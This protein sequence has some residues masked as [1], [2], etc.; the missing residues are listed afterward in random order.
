V[1]PNQPNLTATQRSTNPI[2]HNWAY[3]RIALPI[4]ALL[5][6]GAS[7]EKLAWS[8]AIGL[9]IGINPLLGS[10][11]VLCLV[12][13]SL[14]RLN[15]AASQLANHIVYPLELILI[16]PFI[17]IASR[18]FH[19]APMPLSANEL[20]RAARQRPLDL[21]R[22]LWHWE[23]HAFLLWAAIA[24]VAIPLIALALTPLLRKLLV[25]VEHHQ[26][27]ILHPS[28]PSA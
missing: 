8:I 26:Y 21:T 14:F 16:I 15:L 3:R 6:M 18:I 24:T 22:Q 19:S 1:K 28:D 23:W 13:A 4:L 2:H 20:L 11:T 10:T 25:R 7:P 12:A 27:P 9:L 5:R 17:R